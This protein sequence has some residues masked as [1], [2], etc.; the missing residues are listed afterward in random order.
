MFEEKKDGAPVDMFADTDKAKSSPAPL[1]TVGDLEDEEGSGNPL[2]NKKTILIAVG[3][4]VA[5]TLIGIALQLF[6][7]KKPTSQAPAQQQELQAPGEQAAQQAQDTAELAPSPN[8]GSQPS[9]QEQVAPVTAAPTTDADGDGLTDEEETT[10]ATDINLVDTDGD[11]LSDREEVKVYSTD[12][13]KSDTDA[14]GYS[15]G[16]E[17]KNGFDPKGQGKLLN[18]PTVDDFSGS[19][20]ASGDAA[21]EVK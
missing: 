19:A 13:I 3:A 11:G 6:V 7:F 4:L 9:P 20:K 17:V 1:P 2:L 10:L 12:P 16:Q 14:D 8:D 5:I 18:V 15:D 21:A